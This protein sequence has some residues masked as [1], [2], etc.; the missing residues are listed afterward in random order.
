LST[1][2]CCIRKKLVRGTPEELV[3]QALLGHLVGPFGCPSSL[4][5]VEISLS[6]LA[7]YVP[8]RIKHRRADIVCFTKTVDGARPLVL[9][10]CKRSHPSVDV[11]AQLCGYNMYVGCNVVAVA[12]PNSIAIYAKGRLLYHGAHSCMPSY[13]DLQ[14]IL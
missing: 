6:N 4:I 13:F 2:L 12:W 8:S 3:R 14:K 7:C 10:E 9:I 11:I 1:I 5:S